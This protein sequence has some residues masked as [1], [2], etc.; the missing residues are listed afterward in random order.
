VTQ[1]PE[2]RFGGE[3]PL[4]EMMDEASSQGMRFRFSFS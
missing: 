4:A 3:A 2:F 1:D